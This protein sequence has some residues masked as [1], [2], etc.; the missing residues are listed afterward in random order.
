MSIVI[1]RAEELVQVSETAAPIY[2]AAGVLDTIADPGPKGL[3]PEE[4]GWN[5]SRKGWDGYFV[6]QWA[7]MI[8]RSF[9]FGYDSSTYEAEIIRALKRARDDEAARRRFVM[10][11]RL[12][13]ETQA[14]RRRCVEEMLL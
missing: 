12:C 9:V 2:G 5:S 13:G 14:D 7:T 6:P 8:V 3:E 1:D 11:F 4:L 10:M